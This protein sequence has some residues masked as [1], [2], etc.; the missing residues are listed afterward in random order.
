MTRE[1]LKEHCKKQIEMCEMWAKAKSENPSGKVY[2]EHKMIL[3]LLKQAPCEDAISRQAALDVIYDYEYKK[4]MRK[5]LEAL[6]PVN[7]QEPKTG[8]WISHFSPV[9]Y[10][11]WHVCSHCR[12]EV[13]LKTD[14]CPSCGAEM[15]EPQESEKYCDRNICVSNEYNGI[16][17]D[18]CEITKE[19]ERE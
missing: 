2:E 19:E 3:E 6:P 11:R 15:V 8:H 13:K 9:T 14:Y 10:E 18:E 12:S 7:P 5:A 17:C 1:E 4:D 16:G